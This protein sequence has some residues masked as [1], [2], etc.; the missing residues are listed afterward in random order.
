MREQ[1]QEEDYALYIYLNPY[2]AGLLSGASAWAGWWAPDPL[3][4]RFPSMLGTNGEPPAEWL[5]WSDER[6]AEL[7][8]GE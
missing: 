7:E 5:T 8:T 1:A 4:F 3:R 6:F 2:R